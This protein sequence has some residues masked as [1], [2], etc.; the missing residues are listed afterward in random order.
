MNK[1]Y[2][3][4]INSQ[5][6]FNEL[7]DKAKPSNGAMIAHID[8]VVSYDTEIVSLNKTVI[9]SG[10]TLDNSNNFLGGIIDLPTEDFNENTY[11][12]RFP[13]KF[14]NFLYNGN[15]FVIRGK[16]NEE[17]NYGNYK[18]TLSD[19]RFYK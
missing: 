3:N 2:E 6:A 16:S 19:I 1:K 18:V 17:K 10:I 15:T 13:A 4:F 12:G 11:H 5:N 9:T 7:W 14:Q 8:A